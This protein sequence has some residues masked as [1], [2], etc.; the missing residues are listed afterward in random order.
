MNNYKL[1]VQYDGTEYCGWQIQ[2]NARTVQQEISSALEILTKE[3]INLIGSGRT[4]TGVHALGQVASFATSRNIDEYKFVHSLN[5]IL[6][7]DIAI[8][9]I[10]KVDENFNARFSAVRRSYI[11]LF[12]KNKSPFYYRFACSSRNVGDLGYLNHLSKYLSGEKDFT[13]FSR[14]NSETKNKS[15]IIYD[16]HW[17]ETQGFVIFYIEANRFLHGMVR[18]TIGSLLKACREKLGTEYLEEVLESRDREKAAEA[19]PA[20][21]LFLYKV[22][23]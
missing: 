8:T 3:K 20:R 1:T 9:G 17:K 10:S 2:N 18:T 16:A 5:A 6:P 11:Y 23:Y 12:A 7:R 13:S 14:K 4:D 22:K 15:C 21:G 19:A